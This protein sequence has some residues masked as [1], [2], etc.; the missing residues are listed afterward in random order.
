MKKPEYVKELRELYEAAK[1][2]GNF[3]MANTFLQ[4]ILAQEDND[5]TK[6]EN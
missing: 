6:G 3:N 2:A 1:K 5:N 4:K